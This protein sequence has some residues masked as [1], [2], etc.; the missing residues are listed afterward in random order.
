MSMKQAVDL[1]GQPTDQGVY[2]TG[3]AWIPFYFGGDKH[4]FEMTFK[5]QG[6]LIFAG[7]AMGD[8]SGGHL[9]WVIHN[10]NENGYR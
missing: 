8:F 9:I 4:R 1:A 7:G 10:P 2:M 6:R 5:G 3:K